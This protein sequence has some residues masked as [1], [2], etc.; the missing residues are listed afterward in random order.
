MTVDPLAAFKLRCES[1]AHLFAEGDL[2]LHDA[3]D[4][5]EEG[6]R[7]LGLDA[8]AAQAIMAAAFKPLRTLTQIGGNA[9]A[10]AEP[11][12]LPE[13]TGPTRTAQST[14]DALLYELREGLSALAGDGCRKRLR[15]CDAA[16]M[17]IVAE[18]LLARKDKNKTWLKP[19]T[20]EDIAKLLTVRK[21]MK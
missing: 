10:P 12:A 1:R 18:T 13:P 3:A 7:K 19:W 14:I 11:L 2:D 5:L 17:R 16:A 20:Q 4:V 6:A 15:C 21:G 9:P 8:D